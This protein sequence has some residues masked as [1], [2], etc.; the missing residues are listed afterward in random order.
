MESI[1]RTLETRK[2]TCLAALAMLVLVSTAAQATAEE[3]VPA[4][5]R[6]R[7]LSFQYNSSLAIYTCDALQGR[8]ADLMRAVGARDDVRVNAHHCDDS[9]AI[10]SGGN[11]APRP[12][13]AARPMSQPSLYAG[14]RP[15]ATQRRFVVVTITAMVPTQVTPDVLAEL[16]K[17]KERR[18]LIARVSGNPAARFNDPVIFAAERQ[19]VTLSR[20]T[21]D[22]QPEECELVEQ[23]ATTVFRE[24]GVD[25][26]RRN[27]SC[28]RTRQSQLAPE[29]VVESLMAAKPKPPPVDD[30]EDAGAAEPAPAEPPEAPAPP[31]SEQ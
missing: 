24:L 25:V 11:V 30:A 28:D 8:V 15:D 31:P 6:E 7:R 29:L 1:V 10:V 9:M 18:E 26:V 22:L 5:W 2:S 12:W 4:V 21:L 17:D 16:E 3:P 23:M 14:Q 20:R 19:Q 27:G 13:G